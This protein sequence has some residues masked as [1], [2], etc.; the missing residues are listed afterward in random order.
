MLHHLDPNLHANPPHTP[1]DIWGKITATFYDP[2]HDLLFQFPS[3]FD[4]VSITTSGTHRF[5]MPPRMETMSRTPQFLGVMGG[6]F[7]MILVLFAATFGTKRLLTGKRTSRE[8][9]RGVP[10]PAEVAPLL[11]EFSQPENYQYSYGAT[12]VQPSPA[13][14]RETTRRPKQELEQ[15]G[16][17][18]KSDGDEDMQDAQPER[19]GS[20]A[21]A[22]QHQS[23]ESTK[24]N[25]GD[26]DGPAA[27]SPGS[28]DLDRIHRGSS[29][30]RGGDDG[31]EG[32][33]RTSSSSNSN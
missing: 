7:I 9:E 29:G 30:S 4:P 10:I 20:S 27:A 33:P 8:L 26:E 14:H 2:P 25:R 16:T 13:D 19:K 28:A 12:A 5:E 1:S 24:V 11:T 23:L 31:G 3:I 32:A 6:A 21:Q 18:S 15:Q 17:D 22:G